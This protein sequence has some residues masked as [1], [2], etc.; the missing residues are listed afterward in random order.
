MAQE[1]ELKYIVL[2]SALDELRRHLNGYKSEYSAP[3]A[4]LNIYF[5]TPDLLLRSHDM[6]LRIRGDGARYEMTMKL[7][8]QTI[9]GLHQR[10]EFNVVVSGPELNLS[11]FPTEM[12]PEGFDIERLTASVEPRFRTDFTREKWVVD[13]GT[14]RVEI[15]LD[16]GTITAGE[17]SEPLCELEL[18]LIEG[19]LEDLLVLA[20]Q[21][22]ALPGLRAGVLS[23][24]ARGYHLA[25]GN[26]PQLPEPLANLD[27][28][29]RAT[30]EQGL[31]AA[32]N[33]ALNHWV[34]HEELWLRG[35]V[36]AAGSVFEA[37][38]LVRHTLALFGGVIPRKASSHL[39]DLI[40][41]TEAWLSGGESPETR[42]YSTLTSTTRQTLTEWLLLR[43]WR[44]F[45]NGKGVT[46]I[47]GSLKRFADIQL[48]RLTAELRTAFEHPNDERIQD[49][50]P[51][52]ERVLHGVHIL[53]SVYPPSSPVEWLAAWREFEEAL[54]K[55]QTSKIDFCRRHA[56]AQKPFWLHSGKH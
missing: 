35:N 33:L 37:L 51:R 16:R 18:E 24:A 55:R 11:A 40:A 25:A 4:L 48:S 14:G 36:S 3:R 50:L 9:G 20:R 12:W 31:S 29:P 52:L 53:A 45:L 46:K 26:P 27:L 56:L 19:Q 5:E 30:I 17:L 23:K 42:I 34:R 7:A 21:I 6:G 10:P 43:G 32:L 2:P 39:R 8:G 15:A 41:Q 47:E 13:C 1:I 49:Q 44:P 38:A 22:I 54:R 28:A